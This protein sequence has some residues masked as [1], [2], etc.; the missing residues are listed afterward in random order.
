[1]SKPH[2]RVLLVDDDEDD[3]LFTS[4]LL[5]E[6][7]D[8]EVKVEWVSDY[9]SALEAVRIGEYDVGLVDYR[10]GERTGLDL[11]RQARDMGFNA[12]LLLLRRFNASP[13]RC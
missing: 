11:I 1:M 9:D 13:L 4:D 6:I 5:Y 7:E 10:L 12:P 3:Y 8:Y 2:L